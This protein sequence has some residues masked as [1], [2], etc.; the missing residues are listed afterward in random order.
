[1]NIG[2]A[3]SERFASPRRIAGFLALCSIAAPGARRRLLSDA[4]SPEN[5][6][7]EF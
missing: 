6:L 3:G 5:A 2:T 1:V 4:F 7:P